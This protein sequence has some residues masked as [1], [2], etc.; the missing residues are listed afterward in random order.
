VTGVLS[1]AGEQRPAPALNPAGPGDVTID[2][3]PVEVTALD[4]GSPVI[5]R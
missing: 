5:R 4:G 3:V 2:G 1:A